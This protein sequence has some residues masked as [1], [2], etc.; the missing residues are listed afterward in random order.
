VG[1]VVLGQGTPI[2]RREG[3]REYRW[4]SYRG[5]AGGYCAN[6]RIIGI[7][8]WSVP[9]ITDRRESGQ[10]LDR[11]RSLRGVSERFE[12]DYERLKERGIR[13]HL[14]RRCAMT[15]CWG[16]LGLSHEEI[17]ELF[18]K[19]NSNSVSGRSKPASEG[20]N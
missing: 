17:A 2:E 6:S 20:R 18:R 11:S 10:R 19:P 14:A 3:L 8:E 4:S 15:L 5:Y 1:G 7:K 16:H 13:N 12:C 9:G